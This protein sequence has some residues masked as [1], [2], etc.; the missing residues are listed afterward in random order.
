MHT[1]QVRDLSIFLYQD[2]SEIPHD[3]E[4]AL[5]LIDEVDALVLPKVNVAVGADIP[6]R[7]LPTVRR[8]AIHVAARVWSNPEMLAR[9]GLGPINRAWLE[10]NVTGINLKPSEAEELVALEPVSDPHG[11]LWTIPTRTRDTTGR[12]VFATYEIAGSPARTV[13]AGGVIPL[14]NPG[15]VPNA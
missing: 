4:A 9:R 15:E 13:E 3:D 5:W 2:A 10:E 14:Y 8:I 6:A 1:F 12:Q 7:L 11:G